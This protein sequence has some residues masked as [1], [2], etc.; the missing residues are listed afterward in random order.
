MNQTKDIRME[1]TPT[2]NIDP[3]EIVNCI[4]LLNEMIADIDETVGLG[5]QDC[6]DG[7]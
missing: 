3:R 4:Q 7:R 5:D 1:P 6:L 2:I